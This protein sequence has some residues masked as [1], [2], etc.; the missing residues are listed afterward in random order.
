MSLTCATLSIAAFG[1]T[2]DS[3]PRCGIRHFMGVVKLPTFTP[4]PTLSERITHAL[5]GLRKAR[6]D[7][8]LAH[9]YGAEELMNALLA[10]WPSQ[11]AH[12]N[13]T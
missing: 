6:R 1:G 3:C 5:A 8:D 9:E 10:R 7:G 4:L 12:E 13:T 11:T 2:D